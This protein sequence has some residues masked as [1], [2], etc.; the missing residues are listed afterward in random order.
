MKIVRIFGE[1][2][3]GLKWEGEVRDEFSKAFQQWSDVEY[4][5]SFFESN[6][7]DLMHGF[8]RF[9]SIEQAVLETLSTARDMEKRILQL[10]RNTRHNMRPDLEAIFQ[11]LM[12][13]ELGGRS[14]SKRKA[15][16]PQQRSWLR[17]YAIRIEEG[18]FLVV[19]SAIKLSRTMEERAHTKLQLKKLELARD[20]L[21][22]QGVE[23]A[24]GFLELII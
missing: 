11:P 6:K 15:K 24:D 22:E 7:A 14:L 21:R 5:E 17:I 1:E 23:D 19:G 18:C 10:A 4:L 13:Q 20:F 12:N 8:Y 9:A 2:L 16:G 3:W